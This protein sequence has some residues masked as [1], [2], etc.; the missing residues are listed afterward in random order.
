MSCSEALTRKNSCFR[1]SWRPAAVYGIDPEVFDFAFAFLV[2]L[3]LW[4][5]DDAKVIRKVEATCEKVAQDERYRSAV[6][7]ASQEPLY[8]S[9]SD[10]ARVLAEDFAQKRE[11]VR[12]ADIKAP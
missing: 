9:A 7:Q 6:R 2:A 11:V 1:R 4:N 10:Y 3:F 12:Q 8:R 5:G